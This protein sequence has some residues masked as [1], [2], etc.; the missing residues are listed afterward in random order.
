MVKLA[1]S[2][3]SS[4]LAQIPAAIILGIIGGLLGAGFI[5]VNTKVNLFRKYQLKFKWMKILEAI[6]L[7]IITTTI[8]FFAPMMLSKDCILPGPN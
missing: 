3:D 2:H 4:D 6:L 1:D 7:I 5:Y 8:F